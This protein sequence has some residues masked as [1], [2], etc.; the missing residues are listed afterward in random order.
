MSLQ[1]IPFGHIDYFKGTLKS[2]RCKK[3]TLTF[4]VLPESDKIPM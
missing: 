2:S 1:N 4:L 3:G